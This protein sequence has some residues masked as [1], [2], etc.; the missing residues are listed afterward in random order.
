MTKKFQ[1][2]ALSFFLAACGISM[3]MGILWLKPVIKSQ[4][5]LIEETRIHQE[6][7]MQGA[8]DTRAIVT[9]LAYAAAVDC[10]D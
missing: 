2:I 6:K 1:K 8:E 10:N 3:L 4:Q 9:E 7:I 5:L